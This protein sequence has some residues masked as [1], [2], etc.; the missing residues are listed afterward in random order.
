M[1]EVLGDD[2]Y[3]DWSAAIAADA[4]AA[5]EAS[6]LRRASHAPAIAMLQDERRVATPEPEP[7]TENTER[8][9]ELEPEPE[10]EPAATPE[11]EH[12]QHPERNSPG[13]VADQ[14]RSERGQ[15]IIEGNTDQS[16]P[17]SEDET[18]SDA[19]AVDGAAEQLWSAQAADELQRAEELQRSVAA[20]LNAVGCSHQQR[21][22]QQSPTDTRPPPAFLMKKLTEEL[23]TLTARTQSVAPK[24]PSGNAWMDHECGWLHPRG[25]AACRA[26][27]VE[28][29]QAPQAL[30]TELVSAE[31]PED[32]GE[33]VALRGLPSSLSSLGFSKSE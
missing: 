19:A 21:R 27:D 12:E 30:P 10:P 4:A 22:E 32:D 29:T 7:N 23:A 8:N 25:H 5:Q 31:A 15:N 18:Q 24:R 3:A 13:A 26:V 11:A 14:K 9:P 16:P 1:G 20:L 33:W 28:T 2:W 17:D 6:E